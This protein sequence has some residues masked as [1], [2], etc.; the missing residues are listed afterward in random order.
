MAKLIQ[1]RGRPCV[2]APDGPR[3]AGVVSY[4]P[5]RIDMG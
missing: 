4:N 3:A 1:V 2:W 5:R